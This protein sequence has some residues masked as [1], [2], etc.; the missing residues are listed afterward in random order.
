VTTKKKMHFHV[1][2]EILTCTA[3]YSCTMSQ[4]HDNC[5]FSSQQDETNVF[6]VPETN[7]KRKVSFFFA[8]SLG[9]RR[10]RQSVAM[11]VVDEPHGESADELFTGGADF[12]AFLD[13]AVPV[14]AAAVLQGFWIFLV[15]E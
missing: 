14:R 8:L 13:S 6:T 9:P 5:L 3:Y 2:R 15:E 11:V 12:Q 4:A 7:K 10:L 1:E